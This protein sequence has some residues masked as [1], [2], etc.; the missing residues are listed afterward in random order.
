MGEGISDFG[1]E[2][3]WI[4]GQGSNC[5]FVE[6]FDGVVVQV[7]HAG[8]KITE[9]DDH[10]LLE[11]NAGEDWHSLVQFCTEKQLYG[12]ENLALIPGSVG[13]API[14]NIGAYGVEINRYINSVEFFEISTGQTHRL[15]NEECHFGYRDSIF[16]KELF[17]KVVITRV[18]FSLPKAWQPVNHYGELAKL[19][20][21]SAT[22]IFNEVIRIR[23]EKLPDPSV[24]G[25]AGS[26]FKNPLVSKKHYAALQCEWDQL[27]SY[28]VDQSSVKL[29]AAWLIDKLG[30]KGKKV[31]GIQCHPRQA[32][33]LTNDGTGTG[34][35]LLELAREIQQQVNDVFSISLENEVRLVGKEGLITL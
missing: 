7:N 27:P 20:S 30:F 32:L 26:F 15:S 13:A 4:L 3:F 22:D 14:Q 29:P 2:R 25:N 19:N 33:V 18:L 8:K 35:Q 5:V 10:Y 6:D 34:E 28:A 17:G 1:T 21:P 23:Q 9:L 12:F 16:K 31:G 24:I 11:V